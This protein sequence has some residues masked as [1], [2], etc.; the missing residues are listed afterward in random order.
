MYHLQPKQKELIKR[1]IIYLVMV[2]SVGAIVAF[3]VFF[4]LGFRFNITEGQLEQYALV[5]F[6]SVPSG[7]AITIDGKATSTST[8]SS[9]SIPAGKHT[10]T[11][12]RSGYKTWNKVID[13]KAGSL[14]WLKYVVLVPENLTV[15]SVA[16]YDSVSE[17]LTSPKSRYMLIESK[18][19]TPT[20]ELV[21]LS[22]DTIKASKLTIPASVYSESNTIGV[23]HSF[24][25]QSWDSGERY[26]IVKHTY[27]DKTEWLALDTQ[28]VDLTKNITKLLDIDIS[29][30]SFFG[31]SGN[32]YYALSANNLRKLDLAAGT[33]SKVLISN[34]DNFDIY[35][36]SVITFTGHNI[37]NQ[38]VAGVY[39]DGDAIS[40]ILKTNSVDDK[41]VLNI[42]ITRYFNDN[43][44]AISDG[45]SV[46][47]LKGSYPIAANG[48]SS[49]LVNVASFDSDKSI[50]KLSFSST[51][52]Y[53]LAQ[54]DAYFVSYD[55]EYQS[56]Y[57]STIEGN[58]TT[59]SIGWLNKNY[60]WS[61]RDGTLTIR[62]FDG[63]NVNTINLVS[64][65]QDVALTSNGR[66]FYSINKTSTGTYQLQRVRMILP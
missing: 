55:L 48:D 9:R 40:Y 56:V 59:A 38:N 54:S 17:T 21:D 52:E 20:F 23:L 32:L 5:Q 57:S 50:N 49:S 22:S 46:S 47:I 60:I 24:T 41:S 14:K 63:A 10:V 25:L 15:S 16:E 65:G 51:G 66:Y 61:D 19:D 45:T 42:A 1:A 33:I 44:V 2:L 11:M 26:V 28:N 58:G 7:A 18:S 12:H 43:Y 30:I 62:E 4:S 8:P 13:V 53:I 35:D 3:I 27:G 6:D 29:K 34:V 36:S 64:S 37:S 31:N 39:R